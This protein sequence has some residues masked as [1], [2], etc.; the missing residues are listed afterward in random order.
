MWSSEADAEAVKIEAA[1]EAVEMWVSTVKGLVGFQ[2]RESKGYVE[3]E[4]WER[5][6][7]KILHI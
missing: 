1:W 3:K 4:Y 7:V 2:E 6:W 5:S